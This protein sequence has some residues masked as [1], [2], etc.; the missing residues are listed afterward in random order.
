[1]P[2][3]TSSLERSVASVDASLLGLSIGAVSRLATAF[4]VSVLTGVCA[5]GAGLA[6]VAWPC[7]SPLRNRMESPHSGERS[8]PTLYSD[9]TG[10]AS[11]PPATGGDASRRDSGAKARDAELRL[12]E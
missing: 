5:A 6:A 2:G 8:S 9:S 12:F 10:K 7:P 3:W 1:M 11:S 4:G